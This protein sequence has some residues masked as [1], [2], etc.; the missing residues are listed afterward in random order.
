MMVLFWYV[1][2]SS[3]LL[4]TLMAKDVGSG[5]CKDFRFEHPN[6]VGSLIGGTLLACGTFWCEICVD[7]RNVDTFSD[8]KHIPS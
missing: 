2:E 3:C 7:I 6:S 1:P 5:R 8:P 4:V